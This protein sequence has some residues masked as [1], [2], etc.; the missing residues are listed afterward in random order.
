MVKSQGEST[1]LLF[2]DRSV[3][4]HASVY[5]NVTKS[6]RVAIPPLFISKLSVAGIHKGRMH[7]GRCRCRVARSG[8]LGCDPSRALV[9]NNLMR[10]QAQEGTGGLPSGGTP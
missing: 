7:S 2:P 8:T 10:W 1:P 4:R 5:S 6:G 3:L 9:S